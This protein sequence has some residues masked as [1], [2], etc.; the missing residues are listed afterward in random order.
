MRSLNA[1]PTELK[2]PRQLEDVNLLEQRKFSHRQELFFS[3]QALE[4]LHD[5][6]QVVVSSPDVLDLPPTTD[7]LFLSDL[8]L[9]LG[10]AVLVV[11]VLQKSRTRLKSCV[12]GSSRYTATAWHWVQ[13]LLPLLLDNGVD[14]S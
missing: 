2:R 12:T 3:G 8:Q 11:G 9:Q 4:Q 14:G 1:L 7:V 6:G 13:C 10:G 5:E